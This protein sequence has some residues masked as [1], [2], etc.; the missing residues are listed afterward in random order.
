[1]KWLERITD[2]ID[3][4]SSKLWDSEDQGILTCCMQSRE[5]QTVRHDLANNSKDSN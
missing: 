2:S 3:I 5:L 4:N 1:M